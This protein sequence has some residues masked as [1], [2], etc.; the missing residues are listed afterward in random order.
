MK[1]VPQSFQRGR[2]CRENKSSFNFRVS[3]S[4]SNS[5]G[6]PTQ[7][8]YS[9]LFPCDLWFNTLSPEILLLKDDCPSNTWIVVF[10]SKRNIS[11]SVHGSEIFLIFS[12]LIAHPGFPWF[13]LK[14]CCEVAIEMMS[15]WMYIPT[16]INVSD[17]HVQLHDDPN[18]L[19]LTLIL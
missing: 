2:T 18:A 8:L 17:A 9:Y 15:F 16:L 13:L 19:Q 7:Y 4:I 3:N 14:Y 10:I 1:C 6:I 12:K 5:F 11:K